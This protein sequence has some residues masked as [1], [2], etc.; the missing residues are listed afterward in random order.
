MSATLKLGVTAHREK[1]TAVQAE[2]RDVAGSEQV[3]LVAGG[4]A[5]RREGPVVV[6]VGVQRPD[7]DLTGP[8]EVEC[9]DELAA[10][11]GLV[12]QR[13]CCIKVGAQRSLYLLRAVGQEVVP[14]RQGVG[15]GRVEGSV[16]LDEVLDGQHDV[17]GTLDEA[18]QGQVGHVEIPVEPGD[19]IEVAVR[20]VGTGM[21]GHERPV[22]GVVV[23]ELQVG[24]LVGD[25]GEVG[26]AAH[27]G[28]L[29]RS[30]VVTYRRESCV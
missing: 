30:D 25:R 24:R 5:Q 16:V 4:V 3:G 7:F 21:L 11:P 26:L 20:V 23:E 8:A 19:R 1:Q 18:A 2:P 15:G 13:R 27:R 6:I 12:D 22:Q 9:R 14:G 28:H 17:V 29:V 10:I